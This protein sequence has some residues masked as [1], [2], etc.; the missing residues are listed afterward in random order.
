[1]ERVPECKMVSKVGNAHLNQPI[2][3]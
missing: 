1:M 3:R 2:A